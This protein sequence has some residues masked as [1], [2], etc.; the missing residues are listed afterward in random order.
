LG[1]VVLITPHS[2]PP[3]PT[4]IESR[5]TSKADYEN[6]LASNPAA[7]SAPEEPTSVAVAP[8]LLKT[9]YRTHTCGELRRG[10]VGQTVTLSGWVQVARDKNFAAFI[11]LRDRHGITQILI[12][13]PNHGVDP[14]NAQPAPLY[15][16]ASALGRETVI[17]VTGI[18]V[19]RAGANK[20]GK[21]NKNEA[22]ATGE[23]EVL[24]RASG[25]P[26]LQ[27]ALRVLSS[28][29]PPPM[30]IENKTDA[31]EDTCLK[32][33]FLDLRRPIMQQRLMTRN[34][35]LQAVRSEL[36]SDK[37]GFV[38]LETPMLIKS[39][40]EGARDFL[41]PTRTPR[42]F[43][44][45]PQSPQTF[46]QLLMVGGLDRYFQIARCFRDEELRADRQPE[47]T[48]ID[49]EM[50]FVEQNDILTLF[51]EMM[52]RVFRETRGVEL[53]NP[54]PRLEYTEAMAK[55]G[56]DKPDLRYD[57]Q[58]TDVTELAL[59]PSSGAPFP[60]FAH[61][62]ALVLALCVPGG[63]VKY[64]TTK[65][66]KMLVEKAKDEVKATMVWVRC[67]GLDEAK[68]LKLDSSAKK[69]FSTSEL[70][71][72]AHKA[73]ASE[74]DLLCVFAGPGG[75][76]ADATREVVG[77]FR[78]IMGSE[79]GLRPTDSFCPLW[80]VNFPLLEWNEEGGRWSA[81][82]HPFTRGDK[83]EEAMLIASAEEYATAVN[84][85]VAPPSFAE[86]L[87]KK[88]VDCG[89]LRA[90]AYDLVINGIEVGGGSIRISE[91]QTQE[92]M[93]SLL[94][95]TKAQAEA[96]FGFLL[97]AFEY[98]TPPHGGLA[99]GLD[100]LCA[101][102]CGVTSIRDVMAFPKISTGRDVMIDSPSEVA[103]EQLDELKIMLSPAA[104][105]PQSTP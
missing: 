96:Q 10:H 69:V 34:R 21:A 11:D 95:F 9:G 62:E 4:F 71:S 93:F 103:T 32:W 81:K 36:C 15:E 91:R 47:F 29:K 57:M 52:R 38:E 67:D 56:I 16:R 53:P 66:L 45:L 24:V 5:F 105:P 43:Y 20:D 98:G 27:N 87:E 90:D 102:L 79:L 54:F 97:S 88:G 42:Q 77:K 23:I 86:F 22:R 19:E 75:R 70:L 30:K 58:L 80:V 63:S 100:R 83:G 82:H 13:N 89:A 72:W 60:P 31:G 92:T 104:G 40:P 6:W 33:R 84:E 49:C 2:M 78:H 8:S 28:A 76:H 61:P 65:A 50:S 1:F 55:Y 25:E 35:I 41:V 101:I 7:N 59:A 85:G 64:S 99:F 74:G 39:T 14:A 46:K 26:P 17:T 94:G 44:A 37:N 3:A 51:E 18:V 48:Q 12:E 68:G 73:S